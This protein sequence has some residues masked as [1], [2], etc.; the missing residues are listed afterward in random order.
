MTETLGRNPH[1]LYLEPSLHGYGVL[2]VTPARI[3]AE[4][5]YSEIL[6]RADEETLDATFTVERGATQWTREGT[7]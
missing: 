2:D 1:H 5:W 3:V 4:I 7:R 6:A